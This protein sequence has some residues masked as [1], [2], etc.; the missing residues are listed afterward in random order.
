MKTRRDYLQRLE[1]E[2]AR[3]RSQIGV[4][5]KFRDELLLIRIDK[6]EREIELIRRKGMRARRAR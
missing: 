3:L 1:S 2:S 6:I 5:S 4:G